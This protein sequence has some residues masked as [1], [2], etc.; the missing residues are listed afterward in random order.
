LVFFKFI[1][2]NSVFNQLS[3]VTCRHARSNR[4]RNCSLSSFQSSVSF[5][6]HNLC[7]LHTQLQNTTLGWRFNHDRWHFYVFVFGQIRCSKV[8]IL[9]LLS[10]IHNG[11]YFWLRIC[12]N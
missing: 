7:T 12:C 1:F 4:N 2:N 11:Y 9:L 6:A 8:W 5:W 10:Y 3:I